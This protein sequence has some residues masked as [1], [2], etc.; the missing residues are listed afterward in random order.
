MNL[1]TWLAPEEIEVISNVSRVPTNPVTDEQGNIVPKLDMSEDGSIA[2]LFVEKDDLVG[3]FDY[4]PDVK[5]MQIGVSE[6]AINGRNQALYILL[7]PGVQQ[8][9]QMEGAT[10]N[11]KDLLISVLEDNGVKNASKLFQSGQVNGQSPTGLPGQ[12]PG[13]GLPA[14][15]PQGLGNFGGSQMPSGPSIDQGMANI[16]Q[17][18]GI[19]A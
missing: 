2:R 11:V 5:S 19:S 7:S 13:Q 4:I 6:E 3:S 12:L 14:N 9:L 1:K 15:L 8:Q 16:P 10:I 17:T 18:P